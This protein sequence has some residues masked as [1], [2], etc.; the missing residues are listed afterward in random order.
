MCEW[1]AVP[2]IKV[3]IKTSRIV[4]RTIV[5]KE[6]PRACMPIIRRAGGQMGKLLCGESI[7]LDFWLETPHNFFSLAM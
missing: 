6:G 2:A 4:R 7:M 5:A 1:S 3:A